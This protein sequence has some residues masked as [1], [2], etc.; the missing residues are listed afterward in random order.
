KGF[1]SVSN[2]TF[3]SFAMPLSPRFVKAAGLGLA[4]T[5]AGLWFASRFLFSANFLPHWY[6]LA[7]DRPLLWTTVISHLAIGLSYLVMSPTLACL[8]RRA[9]RDLPYP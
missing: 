9:G 6:F 1:M 2:G 7:R 5:T 8:V 3:Q 4:L